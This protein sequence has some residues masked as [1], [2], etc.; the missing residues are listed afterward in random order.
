MC[1]HKGVET[2]K[3]DFTPIGLVEAF[4]IIVNHFRGDTKS[5]DQV[6]D[7]LQEELKIEQS[8]QVSNDRPV[9]KVRSKQLTPKRYNRNR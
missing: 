3:K 9:K 4:Y 1:L 6:T 8:I 2:M 7:P 5:L